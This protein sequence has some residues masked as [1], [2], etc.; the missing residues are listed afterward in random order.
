MNKKNTFKTIFNLIFNKDFSNN[1]ELTFSQTGEDAIINFLF[2]AFKINNPSYIDI[3][4][5]NPYWINNT[6]IFYYRAKGKGIN[7]EPN[8]IGFQ[9]LKK[10][11]PRDINLNIGL[12]NKKGTLTYFVMDA[13][14]LNTFSEEEARKNVEKWGHKIIKT[15]DIP[16]DTIDNIIAKYS[17][18]IYPDFMNIDAEGVEMDILERIDFIQSKPKIICLE[19]AEYGNTDMQETD[20]ETVNFL[21]TKGYFIF[22]NT[23][24]N[25]IMVD[26]NLWINR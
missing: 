23:Y 3:G 15:M 4:A 16:V 10:F 26:K 22:S 17:N 25:T 2:N 20:T 1:V 13:D 14:T 7:I 5:Y 24:I 21:L 18:N 6:A 8:P 11:R 9:K 12:S 19:T